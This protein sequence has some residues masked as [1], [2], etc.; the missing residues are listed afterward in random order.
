VTPAVLKQRSFEQRAKAVHRQQS[1]RLGTARSMTLGLLSALRSACMRRSAGHLDA[2]RCCH[3]RR[4]LGGRGGW[5]GVREHDFGDGRVRIR[6]NRAR[7]G[8][9][10]RRGRSVRLVTEAAADDLGEL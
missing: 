3:S 2:R 8:R 7:S 6:G 10:A 9:L 1:G 5:L 4:P